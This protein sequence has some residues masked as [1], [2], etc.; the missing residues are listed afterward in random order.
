MIDF[1][2]LMFRL[3]KTSVTAAL[4]AARLGAREIDVDLALKYEE[5]TELLDVVSV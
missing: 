2:L 4:G 3:L 5:N 1:L